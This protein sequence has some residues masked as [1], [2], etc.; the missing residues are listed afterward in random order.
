MIPDRYNRRNLRKAINDPTLIGDELAE[1]LGKKASYATVRRLANLLPT[2]STFD[3]HRTADIERGCSIQGKI[4]LSRDAAIGSNCTINGE[5]F[6][7]E[8]SRLQN[9]SNVNGQLTIG[10][11]TRTGKNTLIRGPVN[12]GSYCALAPEIKFQLRDHPQHQ[13][14]LQMK[15]YSNIIGEELKMVDK[16][17]ANVGNDVWIGRNVMIVSG[18]DIGHGAIIG[19]GSIVTKDVEPYEIVAGV[20]AEHKDWRFRE[21]IRDQLIELS[22]WDWS[23]YKINQNTEFFTR[24]LRNI[25]DIQ[26][27]IAD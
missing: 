4:T 13:A 9:D 6:L 24:D 25:D 16:N 1:I 21:S 17:P 8:G 10:K 26:S 2:S 27:L 3:I 23:D 20:P 12:I 5:L 22:W 19:A 7:G 15:F 18:V 11:R 14:G